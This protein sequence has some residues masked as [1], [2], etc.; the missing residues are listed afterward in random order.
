L[1]LNA[2]FTDQRQDTNRN[3]YEQVLV[4]AAD[5]DAAR[6]LS[7]A[8]TEEGY[9]VYSALT[10]LQE[11]NRTFMIIQA[12]FGGIGAVALLVA[13]FGISNTMIMAIYERTREIGLMKAVGANNADVMAVFLGEASAIGFIGGLGG[14]GVGLLLSRVAGLLIQNYMSS[15]DEGGMLTTVI[16]T[17]AWL[18][19]FAVLFATLVG[20]ISGV[21]PALRAT[22][23]DPIAALRAE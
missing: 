2:W 23:L 6:E 11:L 14:V 19:I 1:E 21:Y 17:P 10:T 8:L 13:A 20:M 9:M 16:Y 15:A 3:G 7:A 5:I 12:V 18:P 4:K 22:R